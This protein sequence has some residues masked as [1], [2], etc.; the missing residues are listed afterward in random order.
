VILVTAE[1]LD[2]ALAYRK[3]RIGKTNVRLVRCCVSHCRCPVAPGNG[4]R[5]WLDGHLRGTLCPACWKLCIQWATEGKDVEVDQLRELG[6]ITVIGRGT[7][8]G[9]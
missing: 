4:A 2:T 6:G 8:H 9:V 3:V 1:E 5:L 7:G